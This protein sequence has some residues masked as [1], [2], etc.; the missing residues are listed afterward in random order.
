MKKIFR[1]TTKN[2]K[3]NLVNNIHF[4]ELKKKNKYNVLI[5]KILRKTK[6]EKKY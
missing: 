6:T 1:Y 5:S 2:K 4:P 3:N